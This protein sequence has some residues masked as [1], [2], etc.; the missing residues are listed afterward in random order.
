MY[1]KHPTRLWKVLPVDQQKIDALCAAMGAGKMRKL[2]ARLLVLRDIDTYASAKDYFQPSAHH[3][4]DPFV[5]A[6]MKHAVALL[7]RCQHKKI[8]IY[9]DYDVDGVSSVYVLYACLQACGFTQLDYY[10]PDRMTEGYGTSD[11]GVQ[12]AIAEGV[13]L[14]ITVDCGIRS[15]SHVRQLRQA[16]IEVIVCD[17]HSPHE[18]QLPDA[19]ILHPSLEHALYPCPYLCG[20]GVVF[21]LV[22]ALQ[23]VFPQL[24]ARAYVDFVA[25]ATV[26]DIVPLRG[27]NRVIVAMGMEKMRQNP[28]TP[29]WWLFT[30]IAQTKGQQ[31]VENINTEFLGFQVAPL[32]NAAGRLE[33]AKLSVDLFFSQH[34]GDAH[35]RY[36]V[37]NQLNEQ[38]KQQQQ[39]SLDAV[40]ARINDTDKQLPFILSAAETWHKGLVGLIAGRLCELFYKPALVLNA[41]NGMLSGSARSPAH[42][43]ITQVLAQCEDLLEQYGGHHA[44]A[45]LVL[46]QE[47]LGAFAQRLQ[48]IIG[49]YP[50]V[51]PVVWVDMS[52]P[53]SH[54]SPQMARNIERMQPFGEKNQEP[55][56]MSQ[57][58]R[59]AD[60][61][62]RIYKGAHVG[63]TFVHARDFVLRG[64]GFNLADK[65]AYLNEPVDLLYAVRV[66]NQSGGVQLFIKDIRPTVEQG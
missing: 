61:T 64:I 10:I 48:K 45:G 32:L 62:Y 46:K 30:G 17:H 2:F 51:D 5:M 34:E 50:P 12:V 28:S 55:L 65:H 36:L 35:E 38:R 1:V 40:V 7:A 16:G 66:D 8:R 22:C 33:H 13:E 15:I 18:Q 39:A 37:L 60:F 21:K 4:H 52:I 54:V 24:D 42:I 63:F 27:E 25:L 44:A 14:L 26:A 31:A 19:I 9:G 47:N 53:L 29:L 11:K 59:P 49:S 20:C 57:A 23:T 6:G 43:D 41:K 3:L 58:V 56:F